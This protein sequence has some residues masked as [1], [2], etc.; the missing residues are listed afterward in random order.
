[1]QPA[2]PTTTNVERALWVTLA[3]A[4]P[5]VTL[6]WLV[7]LGL[8]LVGGLLAAHALGLA[9][10]PLVPFPGGW[11]APRPMPPPLG[12]V[13]RGP[14][15]DCGGAGVWPRRAGG[16]GPGDAVDSPARAGTA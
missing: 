1:M 6:G 4:A 3:A 16:P 14:L 9:G 8:A 12:W 13:P 5:G 7:W 11:G 2:A 10:A 15:P